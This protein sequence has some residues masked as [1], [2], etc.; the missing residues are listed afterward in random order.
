MVPTAERDFDVAHAV[1]DQ[2]PSQQAALAEACVTVRFLRVVRFLADV[3][4]LQ[5]FTAQQ[6]DRVLVEIVVTI[7]LPV[8]AS[9]FTE[10][11]V[12]RMRQVHPFV[13][14]GI[15][16]IRRRLR[17][18]QTERR[19]ADG[20]RSE[21]GTEISRPNA[22]ANLHGDWQF[23]VN[24]AEHLVNPRAQ[25]RM[26][27]G[28]N[29]LVAGAHQV[30]SRLVRGGARVHRAD[31]RQLVGDL[32]EFR[33][34]VAELHA[35]DFRLNRLRLALHLALGLRVE[36]VELRHRSLHVEVNQVLGLA[37]VAAR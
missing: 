15:V 13:E 9:Q 20:H 16:E 6:V 27:R 30:A 8:L 26:P 32:G 17:V 37:A 21:L 7:D 14:R 19:I 29:R 24:P 3:E 25:S 31:D 22:A 10:V 1:L 4:R 2:P 33:Q 34:L 23:L 11:A 12:E 5:V 28:C 35:G 36:R 18:L